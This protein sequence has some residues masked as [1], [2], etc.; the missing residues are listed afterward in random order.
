MASPIPTVDQC[1][2]FMKRY[3]MLSNIRDHSFMVARVAKTLVDGLGRTNISNPPD[4]DK[5]IAA[6]LLHDIAKTRCLE[7]NGHHALEGQLICTELGYPEIGQIVLEHVILKNFNETLYKRGIFGPR[8]LV[9]YADKRVRH[10]QV[11]CLQE[12]LDYIIAR[13]S[14]GTPEKEEYIR[15]N[16]SKTEQLEE[17]L[18]SHL[19]FTSE[20]LENNLA[21]DFLQPF[22]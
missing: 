9:Y 3:E 12:R 2:R 20:E 10:D 19:D 13:Y 4:C 18:F 14:D 22:R 5:V 1:V 21:E 8:E 6:A 7:N 15:R 11:V 17:M 16:F